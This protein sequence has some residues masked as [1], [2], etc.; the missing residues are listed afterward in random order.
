[1]PVAA[2]MTS[3]L[4]VDALDMAVRQRD[5]RPGLVI[6]SDRGGQ[7]RDHDQTELRRRGMVCS[8]SRVGQC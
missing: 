4:V 1:M 7:Y 3:R 2:T 6:R 5:V 8:M